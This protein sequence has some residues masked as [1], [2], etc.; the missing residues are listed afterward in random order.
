MPYITSIE[1]SA[2]ERGRKEGRKQAF[3]EDIRVVLEVRFGPEGLEL[4]ERLNLP[5]G[6]ESLRR[7]HRTLAGAST[8]EEA[9]AALQEAAA[10]ADPPGH[11]G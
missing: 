7:L 11:E 4:L 9:A 10:A 6:V 3:G 2:I 8:L 5:A 1:R